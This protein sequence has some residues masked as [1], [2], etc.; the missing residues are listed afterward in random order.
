VPIITQDTPVQDRERLA[1]EKSAAECTPT[2]RLTANRAIRAKLM[3]KVILYSI[4]LPGISVHRLLLPL[5]Q[6]AIDHVDGQQFWPVPKKMIV[7]S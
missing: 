6:R 5:Y 4:A 3:R 7:L 2:E 1:T